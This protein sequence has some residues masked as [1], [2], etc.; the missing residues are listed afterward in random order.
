MLN[1]LS[2]IALLWLALSGPALASQA[3]IV[4]PGPPLPMVTL[5]AFLNSALLSV[6]SC[7]GGNTAP[8]NGT[9]NA[10]FP[11]ECWINTTSNP[12]VFSYTADGTHWTEFGSLNTSTFVWT[13]YSNSFA[14]TLAGNLSTAGAFTQAG[15]FPTTITSTGTTNATLP[16]GT[17]TLAGLD[18][19]QTFSA[20]NI[21]SGS[22]NFTG[23]FES[24]GIAQ[25]FPG[26]G[27]IAGTSDTQTLTGK[28]YDT[29]GSGN[30]FKINGT[31]VSA[32]TGSG[33]AVLATS[34]TIASPTFTGTAAGASTVPSSVLVNTGVSA[35]SYGSSTAIPSFT[36][37]AEGQLTVA[38]TNVVIAPAG[39]LSG[40]TLASGVV[41]SSLTSVGTLTSGATG[42]GF[43]INFGTSTLSGAVPAGNLPVAS[44]SAK[45][46]VEGDGSTI[47][48]VSGVA[49]CTPATTSQ[50]GC[51]EP[52]GT[53]ITVSGGKLTAVGAAASSID[54][55]GATAISNGTSP[56]FLY[57]KSAKVAAGL[58]A[59]L[60]AS[61]TNPTGTTN[62]STTM[63]GL[64][65]GCSITPSITGRVKI[66]FYGLLQAPGGATSTLK[67]YYGTGTPPS[68]GSTT[69]TGTQVGQPQPLSGSGTSN[70]NSIFANGG[71]ITGLTN[72]TTYW[73][74]LS[75]STSNAADQASVIDV[76]C[77]GNEY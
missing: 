71:N 5:A 60:Q 63:M 20:N 72:G 67:V 26:S 44:S 6:G 48:I 4:T 31:Q 75:L 68:N 43:T 61:P 16:A 19:N 12:W 36:V 23:T 27:S 70:L 47:T 50:S 21:F 30:V 18:V 69:I 54:A 73:V 34:P 59:S 10:A 76:S 3:T 55:A 15:A 58:P 14:L 51:V 17:H 33:A 29:A 52:D 45:G 41:N 25:T 24:G 9:G 57:D 42:A 13:P 32:V 1:R 66:E 35:G 39:T 65:S 37:N 11:G 46:V 49:S 28:T 7:N 40:T 56:G 74:D 8:A 62:T 2:R 64:G 53:T 22:D 38:G 77:N